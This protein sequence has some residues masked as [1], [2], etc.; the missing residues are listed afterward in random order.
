MA[1]T[2]TRGLLGRLEQRAEG[3]VLHRELGLSNQDCTLQIQHFQS[4][5]VLMQSHFAVDTGSTRL[6]PNDPSP[7]RLR[8]RRQLLPF[9]T[10]DHSFLFIRRHAQSLGH[11]S[12]LHR[13]FHR[14]RS[15]SN[16]DTF[17]LHLCSPNRS[18]HSRLEQISTSLDRYRFRRS[19]NQDPR[20]P[21][22][23]FRSSFPTQHSHH[24]THL[25][26][27]NTSRSRIRRPKSSVVPTFPQRSRFR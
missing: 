18:P 5:F 25:N 8:L 17:H 16:C 20:P 12:T 1:R 23:L 27:R 26:S 2:S 15:T 19:F 22:G 21:N 10:R 6:C 24:S 13:L 3:A 14:T 4:D 11:S 9:A 7:Y